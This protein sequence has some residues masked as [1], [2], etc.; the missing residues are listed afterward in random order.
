MCFENKSSISRHLL[1]IYQVDYKDPSNFIYIYN[2]V[3][4]Q[5]YK[6]QDNKWK[7]P[8]LLKLY[9]KNYKIEYIELRE[10]ITS[11]PIYPSMVYFSGPNNG[12]I[13]ST[14]GCHVRLNWETT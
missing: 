10:K 6:D 8:S 13:I 14:K 3:S 9:L 4:I 11:F 2:N 7:Y 12:I 5:D 1:R